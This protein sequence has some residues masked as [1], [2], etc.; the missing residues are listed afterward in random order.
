MP[1]NQA[2]APIVSVARINELR[3][4]GV[5]LGLNGLSKQG[6]SKLHIRRNTIFQSFDR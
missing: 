4:D 1:L 2:L 5:L 3:F 6:H